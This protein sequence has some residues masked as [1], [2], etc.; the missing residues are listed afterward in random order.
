MPNLSYPS[1]SIVIA[2]P[3]RSRVSETDA[4]LN[5]R[6]FKNIFPITEI[7]L[8]TYEGEVYESLFSEVDHIVY[9]K[10][11][12]F[13]TYR[14]W[15]T[16]NRNTTRML[17]TSTEGLKIAK[18][19]LAIKSRIEINLEEVALLRENILKVFGSKVKKNDTYLVTTGPFHQDPKDYFLQ[20]YFI[21]DIF[22][23]GERF[24]LLTG[25]QN[26]LEWFLTNKAQDRFQH[27][28]NPVVPA[29]EQILGFG[30]MR[31]VYPTKK[32]RG[33]INRY[34]LLF[35]ERLLIRNFVKS[36][37]LVIPDEYLGLASGRLSSY[38]FSKLST[39]SMYEKY[40]K[41]RDEEDSYW[42][43]FPFIRV[44]N[45]QG[46]TTIKFLRIFSSWQI[47]RVLVKIGIIG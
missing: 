22:Q 36:K 37:W 9:S 17:L 46:K 4:I 45:M 23:I 14:K 20:P 30:F 3:I 7:I 33:P 47:R 28:S 1:L 10:D 34:L 6:S 21:S 25:W 11:P 2:G 40:L 43:R 15:S 38:D 32:M 35:S 31:S 42:T 39:I 8:S 19:Q 18:M 12:G 26:A 5:V 16:V 41:M 44:L 13:D 24:S 29:N 27:L